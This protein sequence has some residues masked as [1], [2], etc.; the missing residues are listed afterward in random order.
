MIGTRWRRVLKVLKI[1]G[2]YSSSS[3][4]EYQRVGCGPRLRALWVYE[5]RAA[6]R[7]AEKG[8]SPY[9]ASYRFRHAEVGRGATQSHM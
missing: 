3:S 1:D 6:R 2:L 8:S 9:R 7:W 5:G 4:T